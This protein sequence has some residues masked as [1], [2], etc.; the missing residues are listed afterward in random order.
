MGDLVTQTGG[1]FAPLAIAVTGALIFS[2]AAAHRAWAFY[3]VRSTPTTPA[4]ALRRHCAPAPPPVNARPHL[5]T[6]GYIA[7][8]FVIPFALVTVAVTIATLHRISLDERFHNEAQTATAAVLS[9][10]AHHR[11]YALRYQFAVGGKTFEGTQRMP[12][13]ASLEKARKAGHVEISYLRSYPGI[14]RGAAERDLPILVGMLPIALLALVVA[15]PLAQLRGD[16][17]LARIGRS[18]S[19]I[20][21]GVLPG[22]RLSYWIYYD[23]LD[24]GGCVRRGKSWLR[25]SPG[26]CYFTGG[27]VEVLYDPDRPRRN[28]VKASLCWQ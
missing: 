22:L 28:A 23:F 3:R 17:V 10:S 6:G 8:F 27:A 20:V 2:Y 5:A 15:I 4:D 26:A 25:S 12:S 13:F 11:D 16:Y 18:A 7:W 19:A 9:A 24:D 21:V 14:S 1:T